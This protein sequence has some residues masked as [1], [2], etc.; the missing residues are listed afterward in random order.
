MSALG[1]QRRSVEGKQR[2]L[3]KYIEQNGVC[4]LC[5]EGFPIE[6]M[7]RDHIIPRSKGGSPKWENIQL[8]CA[9]CNVAKGDLMP[10]EFAL[11]K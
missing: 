10:D 7:T 8:A 5:G 3:S 6:E 9:P 4:A 2:W 11:K 1:W